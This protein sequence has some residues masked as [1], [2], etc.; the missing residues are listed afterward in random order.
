MDYFKKLEDL[1]EESKELYKKKSKLIDD[2]EKEIAR[3]EQ[4]FEQKMDDCRE[5]ISSNEAKRRNIKS[6]IWETSFF[7]LEK[8]AYAMAS[9]VSQYEG[10]KY[11][12]NQLY[13]DIDN[14]LFDEI[15]CIAPCTLDLYDSRINRKNLMENSDVL[16]LPNTEKS[17]CLLRFDIN[18]E[19]VN[20]DYGKFKY[21]E[22]FVKFVINYRLSTGMYYDYCLGD[23]VNSFLL[24][25]SD[26]IKSRKKERE[27]QK[28][29]VLS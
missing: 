19:L 7:D 11:A 6:K 16:I 3:V 5:E 22:D 20:I 21:L 1:S 18:Q 8:M 15:N 10:E 24:L 27:K 29:L 25:K 13:I 23:L 26:E 9:I 28:K 2:K 12:Y 17:I 14:N 4:K